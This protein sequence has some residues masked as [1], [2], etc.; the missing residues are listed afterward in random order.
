MNVLD[1][2]SK[3]TLKALRRNTGGKKDKNN[4]KKRLRRIELQ[5]EQLTQLVLQNANQNSTK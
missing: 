5:M 1:D 3:T 4:S 2:T